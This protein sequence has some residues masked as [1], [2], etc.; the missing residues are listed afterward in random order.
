MEPRFTRPTGGSMMVYRGQIYHKSVEDGVW[1][2][3]EPHRDHG[4]EGEWFLGKLG[5]K[6][7]T[8][9][10]ER[11]LENSDMWVPVSDT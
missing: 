10:H 3:I 9:V 11:D 8:R 7:F 2:I 6:I 5:S 1:E 4:H